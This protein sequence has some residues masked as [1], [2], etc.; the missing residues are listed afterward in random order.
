M[1]F[2]FRT[3]LVEITESDVTAFGLVQR[4]VFI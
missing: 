3:P 4:L 2:V 1:I